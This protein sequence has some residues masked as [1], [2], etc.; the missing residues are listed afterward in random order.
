MPLMLFSEAGVIVPRGSSYPDSRM[1][2]VDKM[3]VDISID[4]LFVKVKIME[5]FKNNKNYDQEGEYIFTM[6][7]NAMI[8]N[9][10]IWEDGNRIKGVIMEKKKARNLYEK[11]KAR[12]ID[13]GLFEQ[14]NN[15][16]V[17]KFK[18]NIYPIPANGYKRIEIEYTELLAVNFLKMSYYLP[19][20]PV[21]FKNY[22]S[23]IKNF[24]FNFSYNNKIQY[25]TMKWT[26]PFGDNDT[27]NKNFS[28][29]V[30]DKDKVSFNYKNTDVVLDK[31]FIFTLDYLFKD[32]TL[33][34]LTYRDT[35]KTRID[36]SPTNNG[37]RYQDKNGFF[38]GDLYINHNDKSNDKF[39][40]P[41]N[42]V[43]I[44]DRSLSMKWLKLSKSVEIFKKVFESMHKGDKFKVLTFSN[45][46]EPIN[47]DFQDANEA[48]IKEVY[49]KL[50][51]MN[52]KNGTDILSLVNI[53]KKEKKNTY[54]YWI[55]DGQ[56][57][58]NEIRDKELLS[59]F[60]QLSNLKF[61]VLGV[62]SDVNR[63]FLN[64]ITA[65]SNGYYL[66]F[67]ENEEINLK[68]ELFNKAINQEPLLGFS[69]KFKDKNSVKDVYTLQQ[70]TVYDKSVYS[71]VGKYD[72]PTKTSISLN[73][74]N[75]TK[76]EFK[77]EFPESNKKNEYIKRIWAKARID[78]LLDL[79][80]ND[81]EKKEW[82]DEIIS[83]SKEF[84]IVTPYTS[85]LAAPRS[86][87]RPRSIIPGD[88]VLRVKTDD[89]IESVIAKFEFGLTTKL[90][91]IASKKIWEIRFL[92]PDY[93]KD[94]DYKVDLF[95]TAKDGSSIIETKSI[96]I[97]STPPIIK[98]R[99]ELNGDD[100]KFI[101][102]ASKDT[103]KIYAYID[104]KIV[105]IRYSNEDGHS[106]GILPNGKSYNGR[107]IKYILEDFAH[108]SSTV[109][110]II[111]F[112]E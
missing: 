75:N 83:L 24:E 56:A 32:T 60:K 112:R 54:V 7:D 65:M 35:Q 79:I 26:S 61:F 41:K 63:L 25:E 12:L 3:R 17:N 37:K 105:N 11:I 47:N 48:N 14:E 90:K 29:V 34:F 64:K 103:K 76:E 22:K 55:T 23:D 81:G 9:F 97:D 45:I 94:G 92:A 4:S 77:I 19:L 49:N 110:D 2:S 58:L 78:Y 40:E 5:I 88:P 82:I 89:G 111:S 57:T 84:T 15:F 18:V 95:L 104:D 108:N 107:E 100:L 27:N 70:G 38:K 51:N 86:L 72:K 52:I 93:L 68:M 6:P 73:Y 13:P 1:L 8:S 31:D 30:K 106:I 66:H 74:K 46:V 39:F 99:Y 71:I 16:S 80:N 53:L 28:N 69:Y 101:V 42:I 67:F 33:N 102:D 59:K 109:Y 50:L 85:F 62:G 43:V 36:Y 20:K 98:K 10:A 96:T 21:L 91:Y 44:F 87:I